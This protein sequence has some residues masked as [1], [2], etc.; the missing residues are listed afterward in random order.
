MST[1]ALQLA[2]GAVDRQLKDVRSAV[3]PGGVEVVSGLVDEI[4]IQVGGDDAFLVRLG[5]GQ[6]RPI[7]GHDDRPATG[8][9]VMGRQHLV[10]ESEVVRQVFVSEHCPRAHHEDPALHGHEPAHVVAHTG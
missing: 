8:E 3:V 10:A 2:S 5:L 9:A 1:P 4:K 6:H 7:R